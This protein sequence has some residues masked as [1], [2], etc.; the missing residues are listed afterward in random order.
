[1]KKMSRSRKL[2]VFLLILAIS[3]ICILSMSEW[4]SPTLEIAIARMEKR[5]LIGPSEMIAT[6]DFEHSPWDHLV[7]GQT[8]QGIITYEYRDDLGWDKGDLNYYPKGKEAT[9]FCTEYWYRTGEQTWLPIFLFPDH[10]RTA[11]AKLTLSIT[12]EGESKIYQLDGER[13]DSSYFLFALPIDELGGTHFWLLQQALT[14]CY[15]EY[16]LT[17]AVEI[18]IDYFDISG[19]L[20]DTYHKSVIK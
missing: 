6:M 12:V 14:G 7:L 2:I 15:S 11:E 20:L 1:M 10:Q 17:G 3:L 19:N 13:K 5:Q 9:L 16:V 8:E 18:Q 4:P